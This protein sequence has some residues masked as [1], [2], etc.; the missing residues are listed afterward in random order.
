MDECRLNVSAMM[1]AIHR[2]TQ[3]ITQYCSERL[4]GHWLAWRS[5]AMPREKNSFR[6]AES[7]TDLPDYFTI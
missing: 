5:S 3:A 7:K 2:N 6:L 4:L 1:Q